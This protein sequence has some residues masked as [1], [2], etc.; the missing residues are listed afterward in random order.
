MFLTLSRNRSQKQVSLSLSLSLA[1][2]LN[3]KSN[4]FFDAAD[5]FVAAVNDVRRWWSVGD[6]G[7]F[8][9]VIMWT[10]M[11]FVCRNRILTGRP[12]GC[13]HGGFSIPLSYSQALV[14]IKSSNAHGFDLFRGSFRCF[15][16]L[17][18]RKRSHL[19]MARVS[20]C[21]YIDISESHKLDNEGDDEFIGREEQKP[22]G[23]HFGV[24]TY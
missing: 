7:R 19:A 11:Q 9:W 5:L 4:A 24:A 17:R 21:S 22:G 13:S 12:R 14:I 18:R 2:T 16:P 15:A 20:G 8:R 6:V 23:L 1:L 10:M 3:I